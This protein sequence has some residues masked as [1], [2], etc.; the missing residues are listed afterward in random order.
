MTVPVDIYVKDESPVPVALENVVVSVFDVGTHTLVASAT[1][2]S[3]G[4]A[5]FLLPGSVSGQAY[6]V[7]FFKLGIDFHG[8]RNISVLEPASS[9]NKFDHTGT[10]SNILPISSSPYLCRCTG[11]FVDFS[12]NPLANKTL[13]FMSRGNTVDKT[14]K[15]WNSPGRMVP[16]DEMEVRTDS[17]GRVSVDLLRTG[18]F[19]VTWG[20]DDDMVWCITVP[21]AP[22]VS[23][24]ELIHPHPAQWVWDSLTASVAVGATV[25]VGFHVDFSDLSSKSTGV[26]TWFDLLNSDGS[27]VE[28]TYDSGRGVVVLR[29]IAAGTA[30][31]T[32]SLKAGT[33]PNRWPVPTV[34][35]PALNITIT[36]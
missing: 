16:S 12:G 14:P 13:R 25:E 17:F 10:D 31:A 15:V 3:T 33:T 20:G 2:D 11:V 35:V 28:I 18:V 34:L 24:V 8:V 19:L 1:T 9:P 21:D 6:E 4:R 26:E 7:R 29:G 5:A 32:P 22:A 30:T 36:P 23:L 27:L